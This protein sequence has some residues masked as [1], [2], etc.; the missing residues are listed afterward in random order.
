MHNQWGMRVFVMM[1]RIIGV[2]LLLAVCANGVASASN[3]AVTL[4]T[5]GSLAIA[6]GRS[7]ELVC[8]GGEGE[9]SLTLGP[10][11]LLPM[12]T[13]FRWFECRIDEEDLWSQISDVVLTGNS[14]ELTLDL[15]PA[16]EIRG[17]IIEPETIGN[18]SMRVLVSGRSDGG[19]EFSG[20][21]QCV[22]GT[23]RSF[24]CRVPAA[25]AVDAKIRL[26]GHVSHFLW[27]VDTT[28]TTDLGDRKFLPGASIVGRVEIQG[29]CDDPGSPIVVQIMPLTSGWKTF[30]QEARL[31][32]QA[33]MTETGRRGFFHFDGIESGTYTIKAEQKGCGLAQM[34]PVTVYPEAETTLRET[35]VL[36][37]PG[38]LEI[39][40]NPP[41][42]LFGKEWSAELVQITA[43]SGARKALGSSR[44][45]DSG[46]VRFGGLPMGVESSG[47]V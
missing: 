26:S 34:S 36:K 38:E 25:Q 16:S 33:A 43:I 18:L 44:V 12:E 3:M 21:R 40:V 30:E 2:L 41:V 19:T 35:L 29:R 6:E 32:R 28:K 15:W 13:G 4:R 1:K 5:H 23:E 45:Y 47:V 8:N 20:S 7:L 24:S 39:V 27:A 17:R 11:R 14:G 9:S 42:D 10:D 31:E 46:M 22:I 37:P